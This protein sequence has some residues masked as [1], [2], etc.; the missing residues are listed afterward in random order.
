MQSV[1]KVGEGDGMRSFRHT[2]RHQTEVCLHDFSLLSIHPGTPALFEG[3]GEEDEIF[4][5]Q[6]GFCGKA[7]L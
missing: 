2:D 3:E 7:A 4:P 5:I 1:R 6:C